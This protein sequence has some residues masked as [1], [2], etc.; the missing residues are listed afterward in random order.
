M[1]RW[2]VLCPLEPGVVLPK[3]KRD[4]ADVIKGLELEIGILSW[5][6]RVGPSSHTNL[7]KCRFTTLL[8]VVRERC[9]HWKKGQRDA[10]FLA[11]NME[12]GGRNQGSSVP[13]ETG[14]EHPRE[15]QP[16]E[17]RIRLLTSGSVRLYI[18]AGSRVKPPSLWQ[19]VMARIE[20]TSM[21]QAAQAAVTQYHSGNVG[22]HSSGDQE[23]RVKI[24]QDRAW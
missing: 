5:T 18:C 11:L 13:P 6:L 9:D 23:S 12:E 1:Q 10:L 21:Y 17:T 8:V 3:S 24:R 14:K 2:P 4:F 16:S 19:F 15:T 7:Y 22:S 20:N